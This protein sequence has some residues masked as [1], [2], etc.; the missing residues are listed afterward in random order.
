MSCV[1]GVASDQKGDASWPAEFAWMVQVPP[2]R[3]VRAPAEVTVQTSVVSEVN[4]TARLEE[5]VAFT[6]IPVTPTAA[7]VGA[8]PKVI[9]GLTL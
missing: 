6:A 4:V 1:A 7:P 2:A 5:A 3:K 9:V 8:T